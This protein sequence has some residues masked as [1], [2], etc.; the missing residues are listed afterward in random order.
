M[1]INKNARILTDNILI[2]LISTL[3]PDKKIKQTKFIN[4]SNTKPEHS[5]S[6]PSIK[7]IAFVSPIT[8]KT[9]SKIPKIPN[10]KGRPSRGQ[11]ARRL[12]IKRVFCQPFKLLLC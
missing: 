9:V 11:F 6:M 10:L 5:P 3:F 8:E 7:L 1:F 2:K 4:A 12:Y